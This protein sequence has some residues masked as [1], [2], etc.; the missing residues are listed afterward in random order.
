MH[1]EH[2]QLDVSFYNAVVQSGLSCEIIPLLTELFSGWMSGNII[3][4]KE[5]YNGH[6]AC[7]VMVDLM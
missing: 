4:L 2:H 5:R 3:D 7:S 1:I 6:V